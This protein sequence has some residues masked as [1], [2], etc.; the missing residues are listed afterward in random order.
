[1]DGLGEHGRVLNT[2]YLTQL[3]TWSPSLLL[4]FLLVSILALVST[5]ALASTFPLASV[6]L[7]VVHSVKCTKWTN[8]GRCSPSLR[9]KRGFDFFDL[10]GYYELEKRWSA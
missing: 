1:M 5:L 8:L 10:V 4:A 6:S 3:S 9:L 7:V 2:E